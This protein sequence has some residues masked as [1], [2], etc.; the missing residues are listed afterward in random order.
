MTGSLTA[1]FDHYSYRLS[2]Y[3]T[4][5]AV[6][7]TGAIVTDPNR[8]VSAYQ[9]ITTNTGYFVQGQLSFRDALFLTGGLRAE[10]NSDFGD[11][12][13]TP[14]SPQGGVSY[15]HALGN[16]SVKVRGSW[17]RAIRPPVPGSK[18][19]SI[20]PV[21]ITLANPGLAP[22]RQQGWDAGMD[23]VFGAR[24]SLSVTYYHQTAEN[25][26]QLVLVQSDS[27]STYQNQNVGRV[28]NAGV[29]VEGAVSAGLL[30][31]KAQYGY[32]RSRIEDLG[33][34]YT[35]S[36]RVGDRPF[37]TP[38]HTAGASLTVAPVKGPTVAGG[39]TYVGSYNQTDLIALFSC[40]GRTGPCRSGGSRSYIVAF[41]SF[42][43]VNATISQRLTSL[44]SG[45]V[46]VDNLTNDM[47]HEP[48]EIAPVTGR[49]T[50]IGFQFHY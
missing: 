27:V 25:L 2:S 39:L 6:N 43:K 5:G 28:K 14:V 37:N 22:E 47:A 4:S 20:S 48:A 42:V 19:G 31:L 17:G 23:A 15:V 13:G 26:I 36:S 10:R 11:S 18:A 21:S 24:G 49:T 45:F 35:G 32:V 38:T 46:S 30:K 33:P 7:T 44:V 9:T 16:V 8:P 29:E 1:G 40:F 3:F 12:L 41:P 34:N 50:T